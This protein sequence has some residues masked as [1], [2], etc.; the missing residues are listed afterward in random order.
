MYRASILFELPAEKYTFK[1]NDLPKASCVDSI[2]ERFDRRQE[3]S[4]LNWKPGLRIH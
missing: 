2:K 1:R 3:R 4:A